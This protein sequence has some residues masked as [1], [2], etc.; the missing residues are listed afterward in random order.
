MMEAIISSETL[1]L[2][3]AI[4]RHI[5]ER[6]ILHI[7]VTYK[8]RN[9]KRKAST[10]LSKNII[11]LVRKNTGNIRGSALKFSNVR[12]NYITSSHYRTVL[13]TDW[14]IDLNYDL[15][16]VRKICSNFMKWNANLIHSEKHNV[17]PMTLNS[18]KYYLKK[19]IS[20][21]Q[22]SWFA[23]RDMTLI[24]HPPLRTFKCFE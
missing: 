16:K 1:V 18:Y 9:I 11:K 3:R 22:C 12:L 7:S 5:L 17:T 10:W 2:V 6:G 4:R 14:P 15:Q 21:N 8:F 23:S 19:S 13:W 24:S 20:V